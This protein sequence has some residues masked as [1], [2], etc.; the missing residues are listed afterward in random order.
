MS[1]DNAY[2]MGGFQQSEALLGLGPCC[3]KPEQKCST[4]K[5]SLWEKNLLAWS[6]ILAAL[7][8]N[9]NIPAN[10]KEAGC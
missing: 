5:S 4:Q 10:A 2:R 1:D 6:M 8:T 7:D 3:A 9:E